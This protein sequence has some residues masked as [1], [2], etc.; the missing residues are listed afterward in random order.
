[1][2]ESFRHL[3]NGPM[4][5]LSNVQPIIPWAGSKGDSTLYIPAKEFDLVGRYA[6]LLNRIPLASAI[7]ALVDFFFVNAEEDVIIGEMMDDTE[8]GNIMDIE[9]KVIETR[10]WGLMIVVLATLC[11]SSSLYHP[12]P[13]HEF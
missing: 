12:V 2:A 6:D 10:F 4:K 7:Y 13:F 3:Y 11:F 5:A 8:A 1:M 9:G